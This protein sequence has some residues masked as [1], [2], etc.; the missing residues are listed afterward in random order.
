MTVSGAPEFNKDGLGW[1]KKPFSETRRLRDELRMTH[2]RV[3][4]QEAERN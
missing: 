1:T 4:A 2:A 3:A